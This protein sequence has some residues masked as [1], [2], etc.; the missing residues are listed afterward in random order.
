MLMLHVTQ[1]ILLCNPSVCNKL[2]VTV[3]VEP[4]V[5]SFHVGQ[6]NAGDFH[7]GST[8]G[9]HRVWH[10]CGQVGTVFSVLIP[11]EVKSRFARNKQTFIKFVVYTRVCGELCSKQLLHFSF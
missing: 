11:Q 1:W 8:A 4:G 9:Q 10:C 3:A 2:H 7:V 6:R 5:Q